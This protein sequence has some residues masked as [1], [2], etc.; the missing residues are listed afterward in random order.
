MEL[1]LTWAVITAFIILAVLLTRG[2]RMG[3]W[4]AGGWLLVLLA[5]AA[6][7]ARVN[8]TLGAPLA[9]L[10]SLGG[11]GLLLALAGTIRR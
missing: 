10:W 4:V 6:L 9:A 3:P 5:S 7:A 2:W 11:L 8:D 1:D